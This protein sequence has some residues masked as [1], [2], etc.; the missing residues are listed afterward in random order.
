MVLMDITDDR[1]KR[2]LAKEINSEARMCQAYSSHPNGRIAQAKFSNGQLQIRLI[3][4][5]S[6]HAVP[7]DRLDAFYDSYGRHI[8]ASRV[9]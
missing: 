2:R 6:Y 7:D 1:Y 8:V 9:I 3:G 4:E 5:D